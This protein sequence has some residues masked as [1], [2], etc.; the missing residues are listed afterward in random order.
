MITASGLYLPPSGRA[1][2]VR[3]CATAPRC[4]DRV[5]TT[6]GRQDVADEQAL[7]AVGDIA[8]S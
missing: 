8:I 6:T 7:V 4:A 5:P 2:R 3:E 1:G